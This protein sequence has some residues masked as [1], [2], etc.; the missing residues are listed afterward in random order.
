MTEDAANDGLLRITDKASAVEITAR[1]LAG[2]R[3]A[4]WIRSLDL[5]PWLFDHPDVLAA[6]RAFATSGREVEVR[7]LLHDAAAPQAARMKLLALAQR[8]PSV[9]QFR[10]VVDPAY[11]ED[12][13]A[14]VATD[15]GGYYVRAQGDDVAGSACLDGRARVRQLQQRFE[16]IWERSRPVT[17][18]R[19]LG[20]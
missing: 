17:E 12:R 18:Y 15:A 8:L 11:R 7:V 10:E 20:I 6:L 13:A 9:F 4:V 19:A 16:E 5:E 3:R 2:A 1:V 14:M